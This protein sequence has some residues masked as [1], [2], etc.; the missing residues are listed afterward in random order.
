MR[1]A[2]SFLAFSSILQVIS[3]SSPAFHR[4]SFGNANGTIVT[5][6][7]TLFAENPFLVPDETVAASYAQSGR[8]INPITLQQNV[9]IV[10][11]PN[12][13]R[14]M[15][16]TGSRGDQPSPD[17]PDRGVL[18]VNLEAA[19]ITPE[20][21]DFVL[22]THGHPDHANGLR[23][24]GGGSAFPNAQV[25]IGKVEHEFWS[26]P[27]LEDGATDT[28]SAAIRKL[29]QSQKASRNLGQVNCIANFF[30]SNGGRV[31]SSFRF[32]TCRILSPTKAVLH[33]FEETDGFFLASA[34]STD[35]GI[36]QGTLQLR[37][38]PRGRG[39]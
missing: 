13:G 3:C 31:Q 21:I 24:P 2:I 37:S 9:V 10:D 33:S 6:G 36:L 32:S 11:L 25:Y 15:V 20:S 7:P 18:F 16:D 17:S 27:P 4:F 12:V 14:I 29:Q 8:T 30:H 34:L 38:Y 39:L 19:G 35:Q 26:N 1:T 23:L 5:D 28:S 22:L